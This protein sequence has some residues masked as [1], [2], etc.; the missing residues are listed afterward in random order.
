MLIIR[1]TVFL[2]YENSILSLQYFCKSKT[3]KIKVYLKS[4]YTFLSN[5]FGILTI[6]ILLTLSYLSICRSSYLSFK[7][8]V[9]LSTFLAL[10]YDA[11]PH[12]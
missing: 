12:N 2:V 1:E 3:Y 9:L 10:Y 5:N 11:Y 4:D 6:L 7:F 8:T